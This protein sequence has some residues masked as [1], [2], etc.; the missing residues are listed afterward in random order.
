VYEKKTIFTAE[1]GAKMKVIVNDQ[2]EARRLAGYRGAFILPNGQFKRDQGPC[3]YMAF[4]HVECGE[5]LCVSLGGGSYFF[6][7]DKKIIPVS[8]GDVHV[9]TQNK[10]DL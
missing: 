4:D 10:V 3:V 1:K 5:Y 9:R 7:G 6:P 2:Y 8:F